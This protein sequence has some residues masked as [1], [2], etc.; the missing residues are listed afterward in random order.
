MERKI[1]KNKSRLNS[2][3]KKKKKIHFQ[4][5]QNIRVSYILVFI[6]SF[7]CRQIVAIFILTS[8]TFSFFHPSL[9]FPFLYILCPSFVFSFT[10]FSFFLSPITFPVRAFPLLLQPMLSL[11]IAFYK[12]KFGNHNK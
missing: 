7:L 6:F 5:P 1:E 12:N 10:F 2:E 11:N 9:S 3:C 8:L 4:P